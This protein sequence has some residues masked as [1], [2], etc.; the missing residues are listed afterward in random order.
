[1]FP[2]LLG[3]SE[4]KEKISDCL[5]T[6]WCSGHEGNGNYKWYDGICYFVDSMVEKQKHFHLATKNKRKFLKS[7]IVICFNIFCLGSL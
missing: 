6:I 4:R 2:F 7:F 5:R 1:M 3:I